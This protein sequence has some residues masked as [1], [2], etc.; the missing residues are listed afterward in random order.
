MEEKDLNEVLGIDNNPN[1]IQSTN[2]PSEENYSHEKTLRSIATIVLVSG[3]IA[4]VI[5]LFTITFPEQ[6]EDGYSYLTER[7]FNINGFLLTVLT[8]LSSIA[9]WAVLN[10]LSNISMNLFRIKNHLTNS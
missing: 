1:S 7:K 6:L 2:G 8:C 4:T 3:I 10:V 9:T 5:M